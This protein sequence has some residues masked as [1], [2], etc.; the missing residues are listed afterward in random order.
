VRHGR[1][2]V[3]LGK[4]AELPHVLREIGRLR[5]LTFRHKGAG[6]QQPTD[7]DE[8][9]D[10]HRHL[11]L[12]DRQNR[13]LV[14]ACRLGL[15]RTILRQHGRRGFYLHSLFH[16]KKELVPVLRQSLELGKSFVRPEYQ[17][18][19]QLLALLWKG[20]AEYLS[21]HPEYQYLL[22]PV[23]ISNCFSMA[24]KAVMAEYLRRHFFDTELAA[25]VRPRKR[26]RY[27]PLNNDVS[28]PTPLQAGL[29]DAQH[30]QHFVGGLEPGGSGVPV[31]LRQYFKQHAHLLGFNLD[32]GFSNTLNG[33][34]LLDAR[35]LPARTHRL[36]GRYDQPT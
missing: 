33:L 17:C 20:I 22:G 23:S 11:F 18:Q 4:Q 29:D 6:A 31:P 35:E 24:S 26:F 30:L 27:R 12:Y 25:H 16:L 15:G 21:A 1:W 7:L 14:G 32:P 5:E 28:G 13:L 9:D 3:Y 8:Y 19:P 36:L 34:L 10:Y 2:E